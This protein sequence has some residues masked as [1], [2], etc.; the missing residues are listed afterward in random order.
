MVDALQ[1]S[2]RALL[3]TLEEI[4]QVLSA[5]GRPA[6]SLQNIVGLI[7]ERFGTDVC[8]VY[9]LEPDRKHLVLAATVGLRPDAIGRVRMRCNEGL[10]GLVAEQMRPQAFTDAAAASRG[11][12]SFPKRARKSITRCSACRWSTGVRCKECWSCRRP[13]RASFRAARSACSWPPRRS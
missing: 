8:S 6:E 4:G 1:S 12:S 13:N 5:N 7:R 10:V 11:S 3:V 9:L 2:E